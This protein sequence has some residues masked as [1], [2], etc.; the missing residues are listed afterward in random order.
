MRD[1]PS[2]ETPF[3]ALLRQA[4]L[5]GLDGELAQIPSD[6]ELAQTL[7]FSEVHE[8][9]MKALLAKDARRERLQTALRRTRRAAL[10]AAV[11]IVISFGAL[12]I[13]P[14]VRAAVVETVIRWF[15]Q[16]TE[17]ASQ[18]TPLEPAASL[19][20]PA[21]IPEGF[22]ETD[23]FEEYF[24]KSITYANDQGSILLFTGLDAS[25]STSVNNEGVEYRQVLVGETIYHT[26]TALTET[27][28]STVVWDMGGIRFNISAALSM[29]ELL[30][31]AQSVQ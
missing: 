17:F 18:K 12:M 5:S 9:R 21:Y 4:L 29:E 3:D 26:F 8:T 10:A 25:S 30:R 11:V 24:F 15:S 28:E 22:V 16:Y 1:K 2:G 6:E 13:S 7:A 23:R 14:N 31:V 27:V 20:E 19:A